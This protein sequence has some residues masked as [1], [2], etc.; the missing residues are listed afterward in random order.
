MNIAGL[1]LEDDMHH[2]DHIAPLCHLFNI[3]LIVMN[4]EIEK[5][6]KT[7]YP[8]VK[9]VCFNTPNF[10]DRITANFELL[11]TCLP[12]PLFDQTFFFSQQFQKKQIYTIW[13]PHGNSD[14]GRA[15]FFLEVLQDEK[16]LLI[17]GKRMEN[18]L[19]EKGIN[20]KFITIG[21][22]RLNYYKKHKKFYDSI[23]LNEILDKFK[24]KNRVIL[25]APTWKDQEDNSSFLEAF[26]KLLKHLPNKYNLLIKL[27]PNLVKQFP[28][29]IK[30]LQNKSKNHPNLLFLNSFPPIYPLLNFTDIYLG[31]MSSISYDFLTFNRPMFFLSKKKPVDLHLY[32]KAIAPE[33]YPEI[34]S[35][36]D[37][38]LSNENFKKERKKLYHETFS[39]EKSLLL[40]QKELHEIYRN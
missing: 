18:F 2:L 37:S 3:P 40:L 10:P 6:A 38:H 39:P 1:I 14:K 28:T 30:R 4:D 23:V 20:G 36:I 22:Y 19:K 27:H 29:E 13:C 15:S 7:F 17:Y 9:I 21:N 32:G 11:F 34:F 16:W 33:E 35:I 31:D 24:N 12:R 25:Y 8:H 26:P 5:S